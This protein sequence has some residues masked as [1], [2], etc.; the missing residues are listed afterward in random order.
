MA[1]ESSYNP[2]PFSLRSQ[3]LDKDSNYNEEEN[4]NFKTK[5]DEIKINNNP[6]PVLGEHQRNPIDDTDDDYYKRKNAFKIPPKLK[7]TCWCVSLLLLGGVALFV[8][9]IVSSVL[10]ESFKAGV[11]YYI[12]SFI[13]LIPGGFYTYQFIKAR[14]SKDVDRREEILAEI[15][16]L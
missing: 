8:V 1:D 10:E 2:I 14:C 16:E 15:P 12:L 3:I 4:D 6:K 9:G 13:L 7:R 5:R 11:T